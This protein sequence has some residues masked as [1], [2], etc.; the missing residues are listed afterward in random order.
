MLAKSYGLKEDGTVEVIFPKRE[1]F[2]LLLL[3]VFTLQ[4]D[5]L[6]DNLARLPSLQ[7]DC[8]LKYL[9]QLVKRDKSFGYDV[10]R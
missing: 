5:S 6:L 2:A 9:E 7:T 8:D 4:F 10:E 1:L 3:I